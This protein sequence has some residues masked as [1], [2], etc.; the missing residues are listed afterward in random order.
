MCKVLNVVTTETSCTITARFSFGT[1]TGTY[2]NN[3]AHISFIK[4]RTL[5]I[6]KQISETLIEK[7][8][9]L[10]KPK[11]N[12]INECHEKIFVLNELEKLEDVKECNLSCINKRYFYHVGYWGISTHTDERLANEIILASERPFTNK[13]IEQ[14]LEDSQPLDEVHFE[15]RKIQREE[16]LLLKDE[17]TML[18]ED[19]K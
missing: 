8:Q 4:I 2:T 12:S 11:V 3:K 16:Y 18:L 9:G 7:V 17:G 5:Q 1:L 19:L 14:E 10:L 15:V 13:D 6:M